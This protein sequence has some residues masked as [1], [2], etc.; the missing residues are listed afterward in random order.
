MKTGF[1]ETPA[2]FVS[3][4]QTARFDTE[5]WAESNMFCPNCGC[6]TVARYPANRPVADFYCGQCGDQ[7][8]LKSQ[9][10]AFGRKVADGAYFT[11]IERL[12]SDTSPNLILL[13]YS[14]EHRRVENLTVVPRYFFVPQAIERRPPLRSTA[15]RA[16]WVGSNILLDRIPLSGR[17]AVVQSG[18][19]RDR[20]EILD[21]WN[22]LR[23]IEER[24]GEARGWLLEVMRCVQMIGRSDFALADVY[25]FE[26]ELSANFPRNNNVRPKIRQQLQV[27]RDGGYL[28]FLGNGRYRLC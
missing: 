19:V 11:K 12:A 17:I 13:Q 26:R 9:S 5:N 8:E 28:E 21:E 1:S 16:G 15:R 10:S 22:R 23:F 25:R 18:L 6:S 24:H 27:L 4:S 7:Y 2:P 20:R 3:A 14:R